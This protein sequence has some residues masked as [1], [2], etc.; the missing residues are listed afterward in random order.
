MPLDADSLFGPLRRSALPEHRKRVTACP[1]WD[2]VRDRG[3]GIILRGQSEAVRFIL[4]LKWLKWTLRNNAS[5]SRK[6]WPAISRAPE[7]M[8]LE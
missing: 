2:C 3:I 1:C 7:G 6:D 8:G 4:Y 5:G